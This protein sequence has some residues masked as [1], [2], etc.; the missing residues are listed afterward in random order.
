MMREAMAPAQLAVPVFFLYGEPRRVVDARFLHLEPLADRS[1]PSDWNIRPH[2]HT[3][4]N[5]VFFITGGGGRMTADG[6]E[7]PITAPCL[8]TVPAGAVHGFTYEPGTTGWVLTIADAYLQELAN[9]E[10]DFVGMFGATRSLHVENRPALDPRFAQLAQELVWNA[11]GYVA[12]IESQ[13]LSILVEVLRRSR[14]AAKEVRHVAGRT[15]ELVA[16]FRERIEIMYR[17][18]AVLSDYAASLQITQAQLR[19]A[20]LQITG[21]PPMRLIQ[22]RVFLEAQRVLLYTNMSVAETALHL[23]FMDSAYFTRFFTKCAGRSPREFRRRRSA[24]HRTAP[25]R[26][27]KRQCGFVLYLL[28]SEAR[29]YIREPRNFCEFIKNEAF[30]G[31]YVADHDPDQIVKIS[32]HQIAFHHLGVA[33]YCRL[34]IFK[35]PFDLPFQANLYKNADTE[36]DFDRIKQGHVAAYDTGLFQ[37]TYPRQARRRRE[38]HPRGQLHIRQLGVFLKQVEDFNVSGIIGCQRHDVLH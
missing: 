27:L 1:K 10:P 24:A 36:P 5:H 31:L 32:G 22:D 2:A 30:Q 15:A 8:L 16:R 37:R 19:R 23:G 33:C 3:D 17:T 18:A 34:K 29:L 14:Y 11:P 9:R 7:L 28:Q 26:H 38:V 6:S 4:L 12:A 21:Q 20:C 25:H 13:L 35:I